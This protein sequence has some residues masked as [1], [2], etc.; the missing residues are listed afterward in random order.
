LQRFRIILSRH[1]VTIGNLREFSHLNVA[2][3][4]Y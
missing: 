1:F 4:H 2:W 3:V